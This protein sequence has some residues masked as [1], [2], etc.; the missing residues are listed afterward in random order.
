M[1]KVTVVDHDGK[2]TTT[3]GEGC[4]VCVQKDDGTLSMAT[5]YMSVALF[6]NTAQFL[7]N[8][9]ADIGVNYDE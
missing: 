2:E 8:A 6:L 5:G 9:I 4:I 1:V 3:E 7:G